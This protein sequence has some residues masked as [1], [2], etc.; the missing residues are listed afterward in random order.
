MTRMTANPQT[1]ANS[2]HIRLSIFFVISV[3][4]VTQPFQKITNPITHI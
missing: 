4:P 3:I 1:F 2:S